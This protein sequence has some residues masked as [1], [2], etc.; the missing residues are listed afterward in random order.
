MLFLLTFIVFLLSDAINVC[1][2]GYF[3]QIGGIDLAKITEP[4]FVIFNFKVDFQLFQATYLFSMIVP[5]NNEAMDDCEQFGGFHDGRVCLKFFNQFLKKPL[6]I[7]SLDNI[8]IEGGDVNLREIIFG[9]EVDVFQIGVNQF[10]GRRVKS[11]REY[12]L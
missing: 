7:L 11:R 2:R 9:V 12:T 5:F 10:F 3:H 8:L 6:N 1:N 4:F